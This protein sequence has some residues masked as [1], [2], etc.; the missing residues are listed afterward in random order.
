MLCIPAMDLS[1][2]Q[3]VRLYQGR[4]DQETG[5]GDPFVIA[6]N[7][8]AV[9]AE[10]IHIVD[11]DAAKTGQDSNYALVKK[12]VKAL[13]D[14]QIEIEFGGGI[15]D[16]DRVEMLYD[17]GIDY[18]ILGTVLVGDFDLA[19]DIISEYPDKVIAGLDYKKRV[20]M[21]T[22]IGEVAVS[23]WQDNTSVSVEEMLKKLAPLPVSS[24]L[25]TDISK[26]GTMAGPDIKGYEQ[27]LA[28]T[29]HKV[30]ASGGVGSL[31]DLVNLSEI[32]SAG[33]SLFAVVVGKALLAGS[34]N[35]EEAISICK[36]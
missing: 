29:D 27:I 11:L 2:G 6:D 24:I 17:A 20:S 8:A 21:A 36:A 10:R 32:V 9:G 22:G 4:F 3:V 31:M 16:R 33:K 25:L 7:L 18:L 23:G 12:I 30:I 15:R 26:D 14:F 1:G 19:A 34:I 5:Y 28:Y 13:A 35:L